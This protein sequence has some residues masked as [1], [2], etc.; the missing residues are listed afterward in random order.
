M[1]P[2]ASYVSFHCV[3]T[4]QRD[5]LDVRVSPS[6]SVTH[7]KMRHYHL[8]YKGE[9]GLLSYLFEAGYAAHLCVATK[10]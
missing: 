1:F 3:F 9:I 5:E 2:L 7:R 8:N 10:M 6:F 4:Q